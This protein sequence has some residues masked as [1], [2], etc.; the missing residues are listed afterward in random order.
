MKDKNIRCPFID[1]G[2]IQFSKNIECIYRA[3]EIK[4]KVASYA[5]LQLI[6]L[7]FH[8]STG[9]SIIANP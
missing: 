7:C 5:H 9:L 2:K 1:Y 3:E 8:K 4:T 6:F